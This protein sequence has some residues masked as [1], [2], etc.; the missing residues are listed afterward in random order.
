MPS[1]ILENYKETDTRRIAEGDK[2]FKRHEFIHG[3]TQKVAAL[4]LC[5]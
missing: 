4:S 3:L 1:L 5:F 2:W